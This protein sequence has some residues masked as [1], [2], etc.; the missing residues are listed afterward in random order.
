MTFAVAGGG[1]ISS[2]FV[3]RLPNLT[4]ELGP[5]AAQSYRLASRIANT[6]GAGHPVRRYADLNASKLILICA[7][8]KSLGQIVS[9]LAEALDCRGKVILFCEGGADSRQL[10]ALKS[11]GAAVGS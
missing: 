1:R 2:S 5:V 11:N 6:I 8:A 3:T 4:S 7:P 9:T 10:A